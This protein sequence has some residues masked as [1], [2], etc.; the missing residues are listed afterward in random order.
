MHAW[1]AH[2]YLL[3]RLADADVLNG[4]MPDE[5]EL[6]PEDDEDVLDPVDEPDSFEEVDEHDK[7]DT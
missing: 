3:R 6:D 7:H 1:A 5:I 4:S 2:A